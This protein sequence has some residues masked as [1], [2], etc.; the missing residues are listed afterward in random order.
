MMSSPDDKCSKQELQ[1]LCTKSLKQYLR[2]SMIMS[3]HESLVLGE[4]EEETELENGKTVPAETP[5]ENTKLLIK[6]EK[7]TSTSSYNP[8]YFTEWQSPISDW[9]KP[10]QEWQR[11]MVEYQEP[12]RE[13]YVEYGSRMENGEEGSEE[14]IFQ[15]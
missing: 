10:I 5:D 13:W 11:P 15:P 6:T 7:E 8:R 4:E 14:E 9:L 12:I 1:E 2:E 3:S